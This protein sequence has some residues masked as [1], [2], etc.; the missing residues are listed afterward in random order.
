MNRKAQLRLVT[1]LTVARGPL[2]LIFLVLAIVHAFDAAPWRFVLALSSLILAAV[3]DLFDGYLA[4]K[5]KVVSTFGA[6][7]DPLMDKMFYLV[8][9][10]FLVFVAALDGDPTHATILLV[11]TVMFLGR[12][13]WVSFM[14][15][16]GS[17]YN[18]SGS[19]NWA[20]KLRTILNF[21]LICLIYAHEQSPWPFVPINV[22][23]VLEAI[24][25][26]INIVSIVVYTRTYWPSLK[27]SI[28]PD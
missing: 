23:Y 19:A 28:R 5:F 21:P 20:G 26:V 10:P 2:V 13:Q 16:I 18:V 12:D 6:H 22:L 7:A 15:A 14:R 24:A 27:H 11:M 17:I 25:V 3:T 8:T 4:R 1:G 9:L